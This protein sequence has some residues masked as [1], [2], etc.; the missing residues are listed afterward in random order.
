MCFV[1]CHFSKSVFSFI[2]SWWCR[3][4]FDLCCSAA[5]GTCTRE[6]ICLW[7]SSDFSSVMLFSDCDNDRTW[8]LHSRRSDL[9]VSDLYGGALYLPRDTPIFLC[10]SWSASK[11]CFPLKLSCCDTVFQ[12]L[13]TR[14]LETRK[15]GNLIWRFAPSRSP[16]R[17]FFNMFLFMPS[18]HKISFNIIQNKWNG[19]IRGAISNGSYQISPLCISKNHVLYRILDSSSKFIINDI[20]TSVLK[21]DIDTHLYTTIVACMMLS[22][23]TLRNTT[24]DWYITIYLNAKYSTLK[25]KQHAVVV[26]ILDWNILFWKV[27][28]NFES[29]F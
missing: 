25:L 8:L 17:L 11:A 4:S 23:F 29:D 14:Q 16:A 26:V 3:Q 18:S 21:R 24:H 6:R 19:H 15:K 7:L 10:N 5:S 12:W 28:L 22:H 2:N 1:G 13:R 27:K 20:N 9:F